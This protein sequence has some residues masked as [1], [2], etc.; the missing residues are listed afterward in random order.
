MIA[1]IVAQMPNAPSGWESW[2]SRTVVVFIAVSAVSAMIALIWYLLREQKD[3]RQSFLDA[4]HSIQSQFKETETNGT[5]RYRLLR[6][7]LKRLH[8]RDKEHADTLHAVHGL[9]E[10]MAKTYGKR[11]DSAT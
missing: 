3:A 8:D 11:N 1:E 4:L 7:S 10:A 9:L 2:D 6:M 5:E